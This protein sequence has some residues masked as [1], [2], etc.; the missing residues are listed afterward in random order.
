MHVAQYLAAFAIVLGALSPAL[1]DSS[2]GSF[3]SITQALAIGLLS[4]AVYL[5]APKPAPEG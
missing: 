2:P 3:R 5:G 1:P 4:A